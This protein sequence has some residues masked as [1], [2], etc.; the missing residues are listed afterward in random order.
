M[1]STRTLLLAIGLGA[2]FI[3]ATFG[4]PAEA[5]PLADPGPDFFSDIFGKAKEALDSPSSVESAI[6]DVKRTLDDALRPR[7]KMENAVEKVRDIFEGK[8]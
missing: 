2:M 3:F 7:S 5:G 1:A 6:E 8:R 4:N